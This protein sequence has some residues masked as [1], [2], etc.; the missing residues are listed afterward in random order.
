MINSFRVR[1][2]GP[3]LEYIEQKRKQC[4]PG[5]KVANFSTLNM[6]QFAPPLTLAVPLRFRPD[7]YGK[8]F[9]FG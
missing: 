4:R 2:S 8:K 3:S 1:R 9:G 7:P 5:S 6:V